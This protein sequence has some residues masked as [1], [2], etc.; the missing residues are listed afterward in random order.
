MIDVPIGLTLSGGSESATVRK[1]SP[2]PTLNVCLTKTM[3]MIQKMI[4]VWEHSLTP[5]KE[6]VY[7]VQMAVS[8]VQTAT[9]VNIVSLN[10]ILMNLLKFV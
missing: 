5:N 9:H 1:D 7:R 2:S 6:D 4:V 8:A 10:S 3:V